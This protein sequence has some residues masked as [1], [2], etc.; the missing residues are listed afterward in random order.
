MYRV[1]RTITSFFYSLMSL[2]LLTAAGRV[3][4]KASLCNFKPKNHPK[5]AKFHLLRNTTNNNN[6][7]YNTPFVHKTSEIT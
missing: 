7:N 5:L 2:S 6:Y 1:N 4:H 3:F